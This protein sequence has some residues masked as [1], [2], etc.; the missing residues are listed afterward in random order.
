M[1]SA[2]NQRAARDA[3]GRRL[4]K[5]LSTGSKRT[6]DVERSAADERKNVQRLRARRWE[7]RVARLGTFIRR[8]GKKPQEG[9][10]PDAKA[11][12]MAQRTGTGTAQPDKQPDRQLGNRESDNRKLDNRELGDRQLGNKTAGQ[13]HSAEYGRT[14]ESGDASRHAATPKRPAMATWA[15][16]KRSNA[17]GPGRARA[18]PEAVKERLPAMATRDHGGARSG[19]AEDHERWAGEEVNLSMH[20]STTEDPKGAVSQP[21]A[22]G[23]WATQYAR[24]SC[25][26]VAEGTG[27]HATVSRTAERAWKDVA[28]TRWTTGP[29]KPSASWNRQRP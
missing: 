9:T 8:R 19:G 2:E 3:T 22:A 26:D 7:R 1:H 6:L 4:N 16:V 28:A 11:T 23:G 13:A 10:S 17:A 24:T 12:H 15:T 18:Q 27:N 20:R 29:D 14:D 21:N 25:I 5:P